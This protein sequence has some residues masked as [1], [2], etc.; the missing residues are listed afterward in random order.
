MYGFLIN[1]YD[2]L[3]E[4]AVMDAT[5]KFEGAFNL[6]SAGGVS[7]YISLSAGFSNVAASTHAVTVR[8]LDGESKALPNVRLVQDGSTCYIRLTANTSSGANTSNLLRFTLLR[9]I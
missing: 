2:G 5:T 9:L 1:S 3:Y 6:S 7:G 4:A 8:A